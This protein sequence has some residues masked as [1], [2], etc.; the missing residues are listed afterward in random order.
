MSHEEIKASTVVDGETWTVV[1]V[2]LESVRVAV[3]GAYL[4]EV[5]WDRQRLSPRCGARE[6]P[7]ALTRALRDAITNRSG[8][9]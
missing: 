2:P 6:V 4:E 1:L 5:V 7:Q 9:R 3:D 8:G